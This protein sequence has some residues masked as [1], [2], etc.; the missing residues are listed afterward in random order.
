MELYVIIAFV[1][2]LIVGPVL[3]LVGYRLGSRVAYRTFQQ[4]PIFDD[5]E[6][7]T[8]DQDSTA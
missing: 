2:G 5:D 6:E 4:A 8:F 7:P 3:L 1:A